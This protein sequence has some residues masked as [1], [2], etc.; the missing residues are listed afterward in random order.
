[1][2]N[3]RSNK[4][5]S[6]MKRETVRDYMMRWDRLSYIEAN[7]RAQRLHGAELDAAF[8]KAQQS[9]M[10]AQKHPLEFLVFKEIMDKNAVIRGLQEERETVIA[11]Y[12]AKH[13]LS[14]FHFNMA[15]NRRMAVFMHIVNDLDKKPYCG[16]CGHAPVHWREDGSFDCP[17]CGTVD[18]SFKVK[19][20]G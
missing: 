13:R 16:K 18:E 8:K 14:G 5:N 2:G 4:I 15:Y 20:D 17:T 7:A 19:D 11:A 3:H 9:D 10:E 6:A 12:C 1:M